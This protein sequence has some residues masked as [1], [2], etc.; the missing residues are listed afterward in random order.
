MEV[1]LDKTKVMILR[2]NKRK[3][4]SKNSVIWK[5]GR[6]EIAKCDSYKYLGVTLN[7]NGFFS[8]HVEKNKEKAQKSYFSLNTKSKEW[9]NFQP[10]LFLYL[11]DHTIALMVQLCGRTDGTDGERGLI[12]LD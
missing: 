9:G 10:R 2:K 7:S 6:K 11:F 5:I 12:Y 3:T 8:E 4:Q 1:N